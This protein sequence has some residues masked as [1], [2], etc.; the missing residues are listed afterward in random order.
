MK[1][2][3]LL[4]FCSLS[5]SAVP[6]AYDT[7]VLRAKEGNWNAALDQLKNC[8]TTSPDD[9]S[10]V[11][12]TGVAS[13]HV[14]DYTHAIAYFEQ[15][16]ES[17]QDPLLQ[18]KSLVNLGTV[19]AK[20]GD[21]NKAIPPLERALV[22]NPLNESA[23]NK[24]EEFKKKRDEEQQHNSDDNTENDDNKSEEQQ[25]KQSSSDNEDKSSDSD[26]DDTPP[27]ENSQKDGDKGTDKNKEESSSPDESNNSADNKQQQKQK[28]QEDDASSE[29][30]SASEPEQGQKSN[31]SDKDTQSER[32]NRPENSA[33]QSPSEQGSE[34]TE[35]PTSPDTSSA[36]ASEEQDGTQAEA[37]E[38]CGAALD[39]ALNKE[40]NQ[41]M[42]TLLERYDKHDIEG[43]KQLL[44]GRLQQKG[45][46]NACDKNW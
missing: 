2:L 16:V 44:R 5:L 21:F 23:R 18:E 13:F 37:E 31:D 14:G 3:L 42:R 38:M 39:E 24:L 35:P 17:T 27:D 6:F 8:V 11:Y 4:L 28:P 34:D 41:W 32:S 15:A 29:S 22:L 20:T 40:E 33:G 19:Y 26:G 1:F 46:E 30:E 36:G 25:E 7:A 45:G 10:I 12:D 9:A 43:N